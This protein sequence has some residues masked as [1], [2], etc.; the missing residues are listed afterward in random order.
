[1]THVPTDLYLVEN[2]IIVKSP[3]DLSGTLTSSRAYLIDGI[4]DMGTQTI[5]VPPGGLTL[6]GFGSGISC[7]QSSENSY[8][9]FVNGSPN[10]GSL[11][12]RG[13]DVQV[14]GTSSQVFDL[15]NNGQGG[16]IRVIDSNM[17]NCTSVGEVTAYRGML[18]NDSIWLGCA[19]GIRFSGTWIGG[20]RIDS[21]IVANFGSSGIAYG[22]GSGLVFG[23]RFISNANVNIP[24]GAVAYDF[25]SS[26]FSGDGDYELLAGQFAG[27]STTLTTGIGRT[28]VKSKWKANNGIENTYVGARW[29]IETGDEA[30]TVIGSSNV[31]VKVAGATTYADEQWFSNTT[32]NAFVY[33]SDNMIEAAIM[34]TLAVTAGNNNLIQFKMRH[35]DDSASAYVDLYESPILQMQSTGSDPQTVTILDFADLDVGDRLELWVQNTSATTNITVKDG[36]ILAVTERAN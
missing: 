4:I 8:T 18:F 30:T 2:S 11:L 19:D 33:D 25:Q 22:E 13:T 24:L 34:G 15:D 29:Q 28:N 17:T 35:W 14:T 6:T 36:S 1:M 16:A 27:L 26:N 20:V 7:L 23:S 10:A 9:M 21:C 31:Y 3:I 5:A 12:L 32:D